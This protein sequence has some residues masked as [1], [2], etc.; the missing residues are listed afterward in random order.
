MEILDLS[1]CSSNNEVSIKIKE[2]VKSVLIGDLVKALSFKFVRHEKAVRKIYAALATG[3]NAILHGPGGFGKSV[4]VKAV[5]KE[6]GLPVV[7]KIGYKGMMPE[8]ILG[9]PNMKAL[10]ED[11]KYETAFENSLFAKPGILI[12]EEFFDAD[13]STAVAL[14]DVLTEKG[15]REG[16]TKK[17]SLIGSVIIAGN[18][19]PEDMS[20]DDTTSAF[21]KERFPMRHK[22]I[23]SS[24]KEG[25]YLSF[26]NVF[27]TKDVYKEYFKELMLVARLCAGSE[28]MISPRVAS[29]A[30]DVAIEIGVDFLDTVES[31]DTGMITEMKNQVELESTSFKETELLE[32]IKN[33]IMKVVD[34]LRISN[35]EEALE[36]RP[37][38]YAVSSKLKSQSFSNESIEL[39]SEVNTLIGHGIHMI[40]Q[41]IIED[42]DPDT[43][44]S[45]INNWFNDTTTS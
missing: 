41:I 8:E 23:W 2:R 27:Y 32:R 25:D 24:F 40:E 33:K 36:H 21:Y 10:L 6:L 38:L 35:L 42:S 9:V 3:H 34:D 14:K 18:K 1:S 28:E 26:F 5:C 30:A 17:E 39:L 19:C 4:L 16:D 7:Y 13:P 31:L 29:Q 12:L 43:I 37:V 20:I 45:T 11:S 22:M 44:N 15:F